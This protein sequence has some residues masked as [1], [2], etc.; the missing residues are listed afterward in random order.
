MLLLAGLVRVNL[1]FLI[2]AAGGTF[3]FA[4]TAS[5]NLR[6]KN[7][8]WNPAIGGFLAGGVLG[9]RCQLVHM[10]KESSC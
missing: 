1:I 2:A 9:L 3:E 8:S 6:E 4:R 7:D 5:A 10:T